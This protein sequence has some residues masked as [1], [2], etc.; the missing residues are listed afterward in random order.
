MKIN[1]R[2]RIKI[3]ALRIDLRS[4]TG[5]GGKAFPTERTAQIKLRMGAVVGET[6]IFKIS[7]KGS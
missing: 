3:K 5:G 6:I 1:K 7:L 4:V 2:K